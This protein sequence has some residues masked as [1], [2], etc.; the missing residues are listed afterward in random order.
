MVPILQHIGFNSSGKN[1]TELA[2][3]VQE[4]GRFWLFF[5]MDFKILYDFV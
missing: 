3:F 2:I 1:F 5:L 4:A